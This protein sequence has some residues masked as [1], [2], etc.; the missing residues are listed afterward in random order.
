MDITDVLLVSSSKDY[1]LCVIKNWGSVSPSRGWE[2]LGVGNLRTSYRVVNSLNV[3]RMLDEVFHLKNIEVIQVGVLWMASSESYDFCLL[4]SAGS[5]ESFVE[6]T[7]LSLNR[8]FVPL[9]CLQVESP[10]VTHVWS[11][12]LTSDNHHVFSNESRCV[13]GPCWRVDL[14]TLVKVHVMVRWTD[15]EFG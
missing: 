10:K 2:V 5:V 8:W 9:F 4:N 6:E 15:D 12:R 13:V 7:L 1:Q 11:A 3:F 14:S